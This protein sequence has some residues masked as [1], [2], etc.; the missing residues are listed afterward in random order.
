M[1]GRIRAY[2]EEHRHLLRGLVLEVGAKETNGTIRDLLPDDRIGVD[3]EEGT[4]V[5]VVCAAEKLPE[6]FDAGAFDAVVSCDAFEHMQDWRGCL[7][8]MWHCLKDGGWL[9]MTMASPQKGY[10]G[11]P[12]DYWRC[13]WE[14]ILDIFPHADD[15]GKMGASMGWIVKKRG[16]LP[17]LE[18]ID[19]LPVRLSP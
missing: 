16:P 6:R 5:D 8:G 7:R 17:D 1:H 12:H 11:Y 13:E 18:Q 2:I 4:G 9:V 15:M 10:H 3:I 14:H 19:L